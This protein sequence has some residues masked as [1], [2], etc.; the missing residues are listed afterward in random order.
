M[1]RVPQKTKKCP[2]D[3]D[4]FEKM[5]W[6]YDTMSFAASIN[7][8]PQVFIIRN[9]NATWISVRGVGNIHIQH[10]ETCG[11]LVR[12]HEVMGIEIKR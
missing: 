7:L 8:R 9:P 11:D 2:V 10:I 1:K 12:L 5:G 4:Y 6:N 3:V